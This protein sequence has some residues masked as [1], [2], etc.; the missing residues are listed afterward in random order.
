MRTRLSLQF[1]EMQGDSGKMQGGAKPNRAKSHQSSRAWTASPYSRSREA[2]IAQQ[3]RAARNV[4]AASRIMDKIKSMKGFW[5]S[6]AGCR[7]AIVMMNQ[8]P[9]SWCWRL[10]L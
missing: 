8:G 3:G 1:G 5:S 9:A 7:C 6:V 2:I 10:S 4:R